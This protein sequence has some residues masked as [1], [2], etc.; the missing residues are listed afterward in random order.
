MSILT[1]TQALDLEIQ[2]CK[3]AFVRSVRPIYCA[4]SENKKPQAISSCILIRVIGRCFAVT[5]AHVVDAL[6]TISLHIAGTKGT[7]Q[8]VAI[9]GQITSTPCNHLDFAFW[10]LN[11]HQ[12]ELLGGVAFIEDVDTFNPMAATVGRWNAALGYRVSKN[13]KGINYPKK[14]IQTTLT[15]YTAIAES[16]PQFLQDQGYSDSENIVIPYQKFATNP[17]GA[18]VNNPPPAGLSGGAIVDFG[19]AASALPYIGKQ[20]PVLAGIFTEWHKSEGVSVGVR[21]HIA[22]NAIRNQMKITQ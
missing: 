9:E 17:D 16:V 21:I 13:K 11:N 10:E 14:T 22:I 2:D 15:S 1:L 8:L 19:S 4:E 20:K 3:K 7:K 12:V 18:K 5:A 6:D